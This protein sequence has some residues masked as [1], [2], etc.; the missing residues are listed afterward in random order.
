MGGRSLGGRRAAYSTISVGL[1][2]DPLLRDPTGVN[3]EQ[4][5]WERCSEVLTDAWRGVADA[6][7]KPET[8][9]LTCGSRRHSELKL[10]GV[11]I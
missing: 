10:F 7:G 2:C 5:M 1:H 8:F 9:Q 6:A 3:Q 4:R 11:W